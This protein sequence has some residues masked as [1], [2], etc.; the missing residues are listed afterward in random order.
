AQHRGDPQRERLDS[1]YG[2]DPPAHDRQAEVGRPAIADLAGSFRERWN[3]PTPLERRGLR[4]PRII[5]RSTDEPAT[6]AP[7][8]PFGTPPAPVGRHAVQVLRTYPAKRPAYP[9]AHD[10]ERSIA[11]IYAKV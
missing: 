8:D 2:P 11:R 3:D 6:P 9:F 10:G 4:L 7:L 5:A 1:C